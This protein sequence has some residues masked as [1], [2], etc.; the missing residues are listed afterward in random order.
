MQQDAKL[1][2]DGHNCF[3]LSAF[4]TTFGQTQA[5]TFQIGIG[6]SATSMRRPAPVKLFFLGSAHS[7]SRS[8]T[9]GRR[10]MAASPKLIADSPYFHPHSSMRRPAPVKLF[11]LGSAHSYS[12]SPTTGRR[13]MAASPK[14]IA[15]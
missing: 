4:A 6:S 8:P 10:T 13:T 1:S 11:F 15:D 5:P 7:Y 3:L 9:T 2:C 14:L 12:R